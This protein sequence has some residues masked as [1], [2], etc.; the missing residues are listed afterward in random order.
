[1]SLGIRSGVNWMRPNSSPSTAG[2]A[3]HHQ[4]LGRARHA[5][6]QHVALREKARSSSDSSASVWPTMTLADLGEDRVLQRARV[7]ELLF[8]RAGCYRVLS[9]A[10]R[11]H[12]I[13]T[14]ARRARRGRGSGRRGRGRPRRRSWRAPAA[15]RRH[16]RARARRARRRACAAGIGGTWWCAAMRAS[17]CRHQQL[18][19]ARAIAACART[20]RR[21]R[22]RTTRR[23][24]PRHGP[25]RA[26]RRSARR[27]A[28]AASSATSISCTM[29]GIAPA[30]RR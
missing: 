16:R 15:R 25:A 19:G 29:N 8:H 2:E 26:R 28:T 30:W 12:S 4:R 18:R 13:C 24:R 7:G 5:L 1:M 6:E 21:A 23:P 14:R 17:A 27:R 20:V 22:R 9:F 11:T 10:R 3:A